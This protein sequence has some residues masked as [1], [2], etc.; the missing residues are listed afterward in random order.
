MIIHRGLYRLIADTSRIKLGWFSVNQCSF[1]VI[2]G[3]IILLCLIAAI[4]K[5][6]PLPS[7][8]IYLANIS[9]QDSHLIIDNPINVTNRNGYDNQPSFLGPKL[10]LFTAIYEDEQADIY[11]YNIQHRYI[12]R[13]ALTEES[14]YSP[15]PMPTRGYFSV[16][17]VEKDSTQRLWN[18]NPVNSTPNLILKTIKPVGY[19]CWIDSHRVAL[20]ILGTPNTLQIVELQTEKATILDTNIGRSLHKIPGKEAFSYVK[21]WNDSTWFIIEYDVQTK[22]IKPII[23]TL[24][25]SE[26]YVWTPNGEILMGRQS[27]L[28]CFKPET[29]STWSE[30]ADFSK[31]GIMDIKRLAVSPDG[32]RIAI[33]ANDAVKK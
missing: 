15:T 7:T 19:H 27:N 2:C 10:L 17:R 33:V 24:R 31:F 8:D 23:Q 12:T 28:F 5:A 3:Y 11:T 18:F 14:E 25:G 29:D 21:K 1:R 32:K 22:E 26:D 4:T 20:F 6:Q 13:L 16:V 9:T 30:V